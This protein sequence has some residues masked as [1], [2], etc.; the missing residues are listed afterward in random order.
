MNSFK[1]KGKNL[2]FCRKEW[3]PFCKKEVNNSK[4][5]SRFRKDPRGM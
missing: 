1:G 3:C 2:F 5:N 4:L